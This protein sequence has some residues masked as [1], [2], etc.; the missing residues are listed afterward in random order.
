MTSNIEIGLS[1]A[2]LVI[3]VQKGFRE[4]LHWGGNRSTPDF[5][6]NLQSIL[7]KFRSK[8]LPIFHIK[9]NSIHDYSPLNP[10][11]PGNEIEDFAKPANEK[12]EFLLTKT[13]NSAFIGTD[14]EERLRQLNVSSL[15][16]V[17]MTSNHCCETTARMASNFG[18]QV[19]FVR[20][21]TATFDRVFDGQTI[22]AEEIH[23]VTLANLNG[24]FAVIVRTD[25]IIDGLERMD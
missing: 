19:F 18:F 23:R 12:N 14:L 6:N 7:S 13:V 25:E 24:E 20:D 11:K 15:V 5:E 8:H 2:L 9:H 10:Q 4:E 16:I 21:A 17:G 3:D 1:T 22:P